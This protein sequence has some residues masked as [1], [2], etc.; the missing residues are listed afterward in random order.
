MTMEQENRTFILT[1]YAAGRTIPPAAPIKA[2][3]SK[4]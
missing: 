3:I 1:D 4:E 2:S